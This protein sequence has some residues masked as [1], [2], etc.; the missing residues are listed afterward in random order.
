MWIKGETKTREKK[1]RVRQKYKVA[2]QKDQ[3]DKAEDNVRW[4]SV[5]GELEIREGG[6]EI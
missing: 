1:L 2:T 3:S 6:S 4:K 5:R